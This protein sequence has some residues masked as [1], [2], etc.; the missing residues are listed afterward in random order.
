MTRQVRVD[1]PASVPDIR[2]PMFDL[3]AIR[4]PL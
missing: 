3:V 1:S 4:G 2:R